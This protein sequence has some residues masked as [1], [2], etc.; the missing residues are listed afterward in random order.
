MQPNFSALS[1]PAYWNVQG[2]GPDF[3][4]DRR[5]VCELFGGNRPINA[6]TL[7]RGIKKGI[8]PRP[9]KVGGS[10]RWVFDECLQALDRM[11]EGRS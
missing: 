6:S 2:R 3:L 10:S 1:R 7:Y 8:F 9:Y 5:G 11:N 4:L